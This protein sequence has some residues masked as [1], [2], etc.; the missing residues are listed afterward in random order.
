MVGM[1]SHVTFEAR[2]RETVSALESLGFSVEIAM[3]YVESPNA[4][5]V[6]LRAADLIDLAVERKED[7]LFVEDDIDFNDRFSRFHELAVAGNRVIYFY[8]HE[9]DSDKRG[10]RINYQYPPDIAE[11]VVTGQWFQRD[12]YPMQVPINLY[13]SQCV[14]L[15]YRVLEGISEGNLVRKYGRSFD[16]FLWRHLRDINELPLVALPMS[17]QHRSDHR[18]GWHDPRPGQIRKSLSYDFERE[19]S[20]VTS[21]NDSDDKLCRK[22]SDATK[23]PKAIS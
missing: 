16:V 21:N 19:S 12:L 8:L 7:L 18:Q 15:P 5:E 14:Y 9:T 1:V 6:G 22:S 3:S 17:V 2:R 10:L 11:K 13:G 20:G 23:H 4:N